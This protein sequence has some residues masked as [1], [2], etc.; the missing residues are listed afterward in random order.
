MHCSVL[1]RGKVL[2]QMDKRTLTIVLSGYYGFGNSG[3]EAVLKG[4]LFALEK[5]GQAHDVCIQPIVLS[6]DPE[7]TAASYGVEAVHRMNMVHVWG[8]LR[9]SSGVISGGG[10][11]LQDS[12]G[13]GS[14]PYYLGIVKLAQWMNKPTYIYAQGIGPIRRK[15][16][17]Y[18]VG[19]VLH[20][21]QYV[22]VREEQSA[23]LL[24]T[25]GVGAES[26]AVVPDPVMGLPVWKRQPDEQNG[27]ERPMIGV[28]VRF[29][30]K[31]RRELVEIAT[32]LRTIARKRAVHI[33]FFCFHVPVD[34]AAAQYVIDQMGDVSACGSEV[35]HSV[36]G[37]DP[38][39][40]L[41]EIRQCSVVVGMR[42]HSLIYAAAHYIP[43]IGISYDPKIDHFLAQLCIF[44]IGCT[45]KVKADR[46]EAEID[47]L[48]VNQLGWSMKHEF[49]ICML[50]EKAHVPAHHIVHDLVNRIKR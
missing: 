46:L 12:T 19:C 17:Q 30:E 22:S 32:A 26:I 6:M 13:L 9:R 3:D 11:L 8:A 14:V 1:C 5:A 2:E 47:R 36:Q 37:E 31:D 4:I 42:L 27:N 39:A 34:E 7:H 16:Y 41:H 24:Q 20:R 38:L 50:K 28:S 15:V 33:K 23:R 18:V 10:S 29:W 43:M 44:P 45:R 21:C 35:S 25:F 48:L 40:L 49:A